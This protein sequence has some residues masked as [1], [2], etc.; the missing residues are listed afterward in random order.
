MARYARSTTGFRGGREMLEFLIGVGVVCILCAIGAAL[1]E[2]ISRVGWY[3]Y[4]RP[5]ATR[6]VRRINGCEG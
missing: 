2:V 5:M 4:R 3:K 6:R 1:D